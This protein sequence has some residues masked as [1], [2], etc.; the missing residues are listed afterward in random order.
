MVSE[1]ER[2]CRK[3]PTESTSFVVFLQREMWA[4]LRVYAPAP[5][6]AAQCTCT[7][8]V[9]L[10]WRRKTPLTNQ[11]LYSPSGRDSKPLRIP[12]SN[13]FNLNCKYGLL[14]EAQ[15]TCIMKFTYSIFCT[16]ISGCSAV[17]NIW[18]GFM[19]WLAWKSTKWKF[20]E[21]W[22]KK[23]PENYVFNVSMWVSRCGSMPTHCFLGVARVALP[24]HYR[25]F[26]VK[27]RQSHIQLSSTSGNSEHT[28]RPRKRRQLLL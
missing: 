10:F 4:K 2:G 12:F 27:L 3:N 14:A 19:T 15:I 22:T 28:D 26:A 20:R 17:L 23:R 21:R 6:A 11:I 5:W 24:C 18:F 25:K 9:L 13:F 7:V 8:S 16:S 1:W